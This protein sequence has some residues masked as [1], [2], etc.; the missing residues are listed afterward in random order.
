MARHHGSL[1][2]YTTGLISRAGGSGPVAT[3][4]TRVAI[5]RR[6]TVARIG[7]NQP[8]FGALRMAFP[9]LR[10]GLLS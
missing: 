1:I 5:G 7:K 4:G 3:A 9:P 8:F 2:E 6:V 10:A